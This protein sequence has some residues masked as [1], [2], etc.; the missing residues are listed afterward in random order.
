MNWFERYSIPGLFFVTLLS[1]LLWILFEFNFSLSPVIIGVLITISL[2]VGY[3]I[4]IL[5]QVLYYF[6]SP[7]KI[8]K[9]IWNEY[10]RDEKDE[11]K[12]GK[13]RK[14]WNKF[15]EDKSELIAEAEVTLCFR[16]D[17]NKMKNYK[18]LSE[19]PPKRMDVMAINSS[20]IISII[21]IRILEYF[22]I[23]NRIHVFQDMNP[24]KCI[25]DNIN[26]YNYIIYGIFAILCLSNKLLS[27]QVKHIL[28]GLI[29]ERRTEKRETDKEL[30]K[31]LLQ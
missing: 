1:I 8:H 14:I 25:G 21:I 3:I 29:E 5:S 15:R 20:F 4:V 17:S 26:T 11:I 23:S 27:S 22:I 30:I 7:W 13:I 24:L 31:K 9:K 12:F 10:L 16:L 19:W 28:K 6:I 2:P 18:W